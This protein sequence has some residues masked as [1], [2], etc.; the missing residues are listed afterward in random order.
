VV[1]IAETIRS[2]LIALIAEDPAYFTFN[3][4]QYVGAV[5]GLK[6]KRPNTI[7]GF[8]D[9]PELT[10]VFNLRNKSGDLV[11]GQNRPK[12]GDRITYRDRLYRIDVDEPDSFEECL[13]LQLTSAER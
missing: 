13:E 3:G 10:A 5:S 6:R 8:D 1:S 7:G 4:T 12:A 11:F 2:D 9:M